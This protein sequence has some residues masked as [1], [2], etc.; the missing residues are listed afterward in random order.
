MKIDV[1]SMSYKFYQGINIVLLFKCKINQ[2]ASLVG[3][4][5][6]T[7]RKLNTMNQIL[8]PFIF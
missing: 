2:N 7:F 8:I 4:N 6:I 1:V 5:G 3:V